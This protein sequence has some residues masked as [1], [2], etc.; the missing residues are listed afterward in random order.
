[1]AKRRES[2]KRRRISS[3]QVVEAFSSTLSQEFD[4]FVATRSLPAADD[5]PGRERYAASLRRKV[6]S[7]AD[8]GSVGIEPPTTDLGQHV[9]DLPAILKSNLTASLN[10][11][12]RLG[13]GLYDFYPPELPPKGYWHR[14]PFTKPQEFVF[15]RVRPASSDAF[16]MKIPLFGPGRFYANAAT[17]PTS[18]DRY[19]EAWCGILLPIDPNLHDAAHGPKDLM[20]WAE[21]TVDYDYTLSATPGADWNSRPEAADAR[22]AIKVR[23]LRFDRQTNAPRFGVT[24][25][26]SYVALHEILRARLL[27]NGVTSSP[28][29]ALMPSVGGPYAAWSSGPQPFTIDPAQGNTRKL[30]TDSYYYVAI[31]CAAD[32]GALPGPANAEV[33]A[34]MFLRLVTLG[35]FPHDP[36]VQ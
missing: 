31:L 16:V 14:Q 11:P 18:T 19:A 12:L 23:L 17:L 13:E 21:G 33:N 7:T 26:A 25:G 22:V 15:E 3:S 20:V 4:D 32:A 30:D 28:P 34:Q 9:M 1:M 35:I 8:L 2:T 6:L 10:S 36:T 5:R 29:S 27:P 24:D